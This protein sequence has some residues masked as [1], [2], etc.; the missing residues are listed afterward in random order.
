MDALKARPV[1]EFDEIYQKGAIDIV[2]KPL[3]SEPD[4]AI[5]EEIQKIFVA[6]QRLVAEEG[7]GHFEMRRDTDNSV[8]FRLEP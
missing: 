1:F 6:G 4:Q 8:I 3:S 7:L 5:L 2:L